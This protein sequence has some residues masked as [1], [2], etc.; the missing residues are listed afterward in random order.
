MLHQQQRNGKVFRSITVRNPSFTPLCVILFRPEQLPASVWIN[1]LQF[2]DNQDNRR[3]LSRPA[4]RS[5]VVRFS[6]E[7]SGT[8]R[9][10][11]GQSVRSA[12]LARS[13]GSQNRGLSG[14]HGKVDPQQRG[15]SY[16][17]GELPSERDRS[18]RS[19]ARMSSSTRCRKPTETWAANDCSSLAQLPQ[20]RQVI[21][22]LPSSTLA[23]NTNLH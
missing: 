7:N 19:R 8:S 13:A 21:A 3:G 6:A 12:H 17:R 10:S 4:T 14:T 15:G 22:S 5:P 11:V 23:W 1:A 2:L 18:A 20:F 9:E 16:G